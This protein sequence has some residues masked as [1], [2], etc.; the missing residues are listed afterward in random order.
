M[1]DPVLMSVDRLPIDKIDA[2]RRKRPIQEA[3][4]DAIIA[5]LAENGGV[6][7]NPITVRRLKDG[8][9]VLIAGGHRLEA[10]RQLGWADVPVRLWT[11]VTQDWALIIELD[12]NLAGGNMSALDTAVFLSA[13]KKVYEKQHPETRQGHA[14]ASGKHATGLNPVA[15]FAKTAAQSMSA[16]EAK[17]FK[18]LRAGSALS[19]DQVR[20]LRDAPK[21][22]GFNDLV[23]LASIAED[24]ERSAV[25]IS[26]TNG[27]AKNVNAARKAYAASTGRAAP[28]L[29]ADEKAQARL[30]DAWERAPKATKRRFVD[31]FGDD[32]RGLMDDNDAAVSF[33][34]LHGDDA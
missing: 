32:L 6:L 28:E 22:P 1:A 14:G 12:E 11:G 7:I 17:V 29:S 33:Q 8:T 9:D 34:T 15:S 31:E 16:S 25:C 26:L 3:R 18:L 27:A 5:S 4:V 19:A 20:W 13:R 24:A 30:F 21:A 2:R 10:A 23:A